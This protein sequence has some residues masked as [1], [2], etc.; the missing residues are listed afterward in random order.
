MDEMDFT[1]VP[2][3]VGEERHRSR[4][5]KLRKYP[6]TE[7]GKIYLCII[8]N[9][10]GNYHLTSLLLKLLD[11]YRWEDSTSKSTYVNVHVV[12]YEPS[13]PCIVL[14]PVI[15]FFYLNFL[16]LCKL[17]EYYNGVMFSICELP[18]NSCL[19]TLISLEIYITV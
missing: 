2:V 17:S 10:V 13:D 1:A 16:F 19:Y 7:K 15:K 6:S 9:W 18:I 4:S 5:N 11:F 12:N 3:E 8:Q 14:F